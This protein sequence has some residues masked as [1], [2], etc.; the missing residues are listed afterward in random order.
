MVVLGGRGGIAPTH[1]WLQHE[2]GV[3][4]QRHAPA[5][6]C[7]GERTPGT[8]C[9]GGW[10]GLRASLGTEVRGIIL[11]PCRGLN[12]VRLVI[13]SVVRHYTDWATPA[14]NYL[15]SSTNV[16]SL[17]LSTGYCYVCWCCVIYCS[18][19]CFPVSAVCEMWSS[20]NPHLICKVPLQICLV[21]CAQWLL[22]ELLV[23]YSTWK[24][25]I[26]IGIWE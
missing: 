19:V 15:H 1:S 11:C 24:Q 14:P 5:A 26:L 7:P 9:T 18:K 16:V 10:V 8:H 25:L 3:S 13:Q 23:P 12:P 21:V 2:M 22:S 20:V 17:M 6:L 4:G